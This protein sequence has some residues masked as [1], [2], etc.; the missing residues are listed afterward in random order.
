MSTRQIPCMMGT[1][2]ILVPNSQNSNVIAIVQINVGQD[3]VTGIITF[4]GVTRAYLTFDHTGRE[5]I[6]AT[7]TSQELSVCKSIENIINVL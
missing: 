4:G 1:D 5:V 3:G 6:S 7:A 2:N